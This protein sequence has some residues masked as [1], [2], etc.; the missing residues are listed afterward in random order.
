MYWVKEKEVDLQAQDLTRSIDNATSTPRQPLQS[1]IST[2]GSIAPIKF[3][4]SSK[5]SP[6]LP[7]TP[8]TPAKLLTGDDLARFQREVEGQTVNKAALLGLLKKSYV[9]PSNI[10]ASYHLTQQQLPKG[11]QQRVE[12]HARNICGQ[13]R[14]IRSRQSVETCSMYVRRLTRSRFGNRARV[15]FA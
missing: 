11:H 10:V 3:H 13:G 1:V 8:K 5:A 15:G 2:N 4:T 12:S 6:A 14:T 7:Q 9:L